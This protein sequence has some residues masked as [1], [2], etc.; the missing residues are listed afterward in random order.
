[1]KKVF[2]LVIIVILAFFSCSKKNNDPA[3]VGLKN[4]D[5][6][7]TISGDVY[8]VVKI[9]NQS[10][11]SVNYHGPGGIFNTGFTSGDNLAHGKLYTADDAM[12]VVLPSGW[13]IPTYDDYLTLLIARGATQNNDGSYSAGLT[14]THSLMT[15]TG[16]SEGG[17]N[18]YSGFS[19]LPTGFYHLDT[20][21]GTGNGASFL[22]S[23]ILGA[24]PHLGFTIGPGPTGQPFI[25]LGVVLLDEDRCSLRFVKD[26]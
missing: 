2:T 12:Q 5:S 14:V 17:G 13:R 25:Y 6:T 19:A 9:G 4:A 7:V 20:F 18:N 10:W 22:H 23:A 26:N 1:M 24:P 11:T 21:Y 3:P 16:W 8:P 15:E